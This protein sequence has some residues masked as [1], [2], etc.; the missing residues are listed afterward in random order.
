MSIRFDAP[1]SLITDEMLRNNVNTSEEEKEQEGDSGIHYKT[2]SLS[3]KN[4]C[5]SKTAPKLKTKIPNDYIPKCVQDLAHFN[6]TALHQFSCYLGLLEN[7]K[8][9]KRKDM[10]FYIMDHFST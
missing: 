3:S 6:T 7:N 1:L 10:E 8:K 4:E 9:Y 5:K 2:I